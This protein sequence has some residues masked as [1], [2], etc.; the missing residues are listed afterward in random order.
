MKAFPQTTVIVDAKGEGIDVKLGL[1]VVFK[2]TRHQVADG[3]FP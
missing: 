2:N 1:V 3:V